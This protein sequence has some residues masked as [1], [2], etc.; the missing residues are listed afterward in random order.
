MIKKLLLSF[1]II[2]GTQALKAQ[3]Y[4]LFTGTYTTGTSEG[5]YVYK[6]DAATG[7]ISPADT[8]KGVQQPSY[9]S[10]SADGNFLY[11]V[12]ESGG[13]EPGQ[14]SA[15]SFDKA[16]GRL[17]FLNKRP[18]FGDYPCYITVSNNRK[19]VIAANYGGGNFVAY[20]VNAD[21]SLSDNYQ[22]IQHEGNGPNKARQDAPHVHSTI[23]SPDQRHLL[24]SDLGTDKVIAYR[25]NE[26]AVTNPLNPVPAHIAMVPGG[27][28]PRHLEFHPNGKWVYLMEELSGQVSAWKYHKGKMRPIQRAEAHPEGYT[29]DRGSADIH[30]SPDG[31]HLYASNRY[32]ANNLAI[33]RVNKKTGMLTPAG[34][35]DVIGNKPRNFVI[36]PT[37]RYILVA[38]QES[39]DFRVFRRNETTGLLT[40]TE[41]VV[42]VGNPVCLKLLRIQD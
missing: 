29:G 34:F 35:Q 6:F 14:I 21:G 31:K 4:F 17:T 5:I 2:A 10:L 40:P 8:A 24:V 26:N 39:N 42:T 23:L 27:S 1:I 13:K 12:N 41:T 37:G 9:L 15:F 30:L 11:A 36:E 7:K 20:A 28:G 33:F 22:V 16:S 19:W 18:S 3:Q 25:F 38:N 32:Q